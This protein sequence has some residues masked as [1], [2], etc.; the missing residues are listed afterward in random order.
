MDDEQITAA[1][2]ALRHHGLLGGALRSILGSI[3]TLN[4]R[5]YLT[6]LNPST[7]TGTDGLS[8]TDLQVAPD[9]AIDDLPE[10]LAA[11]IP[12]RQILFAPIAAIPRKDSADKRAIGFLTTP[13]RVLGRIITQRAIHR[14]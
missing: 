11:L 4:I 5:K 14:G 6:E 12:R 13:L 1:L 9:N 8:V 3:N 2:N 7:S 10:A